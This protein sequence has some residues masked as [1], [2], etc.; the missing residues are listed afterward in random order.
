MYNRKRNV[1]KLKNYL[2]YFE[3]YK[4]LSE[5]VFLNL[6]YVSSWKLIFLNSS[7]RTCNSKLISLNSSLWTR[8]SELVSPNSSLR[9]R[10]SELISPNLSLWI[11]LS[12]LISQNSSLKNLLEHSFSQTYYFDKDMG[13]PRMHLAFPKS[14]SMNFSRPDN[15][16]HCKKERERYREKCTFFQ[17]LWLS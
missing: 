3:R 10:L 7:L 14:L 4:K 17:I 9:T 8:L 1:V 13:R 11:C 16:F 2:D 12:E 15:S 6:L 5:L